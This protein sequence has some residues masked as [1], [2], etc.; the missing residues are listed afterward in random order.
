MTINEIMDKILVDLKSLP[1]GKLRRN[2]NETV[3]THWPKYQLGL[4]LEQIPTEQLL[5]WQWFDDKNDTKYS[6][7]TAAEYHEDSLDKYAKYIA[8]N[9]FAK[10]L[11]LRMLRAPR[12]LQAKIFENVAKNMAKSSDRNISTR[13]KYLLNADHSKDIS[14]QSTLSNHFTGLLYRGSLREAGTAYKEITRNLSD[15][16]R[17]IFNETFGKGY[18]DKDGVWHDLETMTAANAEKGNRGAEKAK[19]GN[20]K[21]AGRKSARKELEEAEE[22]LVKSTQ[23]AGNIEKYK[24]QIENLKKERSKVDALTQKSQKLKEIKTLID[25]VGQVLYF[26][27]L[28]EDSIKRSGLGD[29]KEALQSRKLY[30]FIN[31]GKIESLANLKS[32][33]FGRKNAEEINKIIK[34]AKPLLAQLA[35]KANSPEIKGMRHEKIDTADL[36]SFFYKALNKRGTIDSISKEIREKKGFVKDFESQKESAAK[37]FSAAKQKVADMKEKAGKNLQKK[38]GH[39]IQGKKFGEDAKLPQMS[40]KWRE[41]QKSLGLTDEQIMKKFLK[42][43]DRR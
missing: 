35:E 13:L 37:K 30:N 9:T 25:Q 16:A 15:E 3:F 42:T 29:L 5:N 7:E 23:D 11:M 43:I 17:E 31:T 39:E 34:Q 1:D 4:E 24:T 8:N 22:N 27:N 20:N 32:G 2:R 26:G 21:M 19:Y 10:E 12:K 33:L 18:N 40:E 14:H 41:Q 28:N 6:H 36:H 38:F